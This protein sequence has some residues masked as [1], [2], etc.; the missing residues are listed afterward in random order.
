MY[1]CP[2]CGGN[3][4]KER[5]EVYNFSETFNVKTGDIICKK[6][7]YTWARES[8]STKQEKNEHNEQA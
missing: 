3:A 6:C 7:G 2:K 8:F 4:H 1:K 5:I